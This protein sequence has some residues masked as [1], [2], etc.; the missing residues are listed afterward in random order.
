MGWYLYGVTSSAEAL[1]PPSDL[2][3][4]DDVE[5]RFHGDGDLVLIV[6]SMD[7]TTEELQEADP[8]DTLAAVRR[9]DEVLTQLAGA[10]PVLPVR[11]GTLLSDRSAA[12]E[13]LAERRGELTSALESVAGADEWV[14]QVDAIETADAASDAVEDMPPGHAFFARKRSEAQRRVDDR[15]RANATADALE[16]RLHPL[17][18][19]SQPLTPRDPE[20]VARAAYLVDRD[21]Q[22]RFLDATTA[23]D[24][25]TVVVQGPLPPYRFTQGQ[26]L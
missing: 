10:G 9:H 4:I 25:A 20:T 2:R 1:R 19:A 7:R 24:G 21:D 22:D 13:L 17:S 15:M 5:V 14:V 26:S 12:D 6:S 8:H 3:G 16:Q 11:F 23:C 18:R